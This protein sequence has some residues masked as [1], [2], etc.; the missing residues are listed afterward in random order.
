MQEKIYNWRKNANCQDQVICVQKTSKNLRHKAKAIHSTAK[1][2]N[3]LEKVGKRK[4]KKLTKV[5]P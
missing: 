1:T 2:T 5:K 3:K 4:R